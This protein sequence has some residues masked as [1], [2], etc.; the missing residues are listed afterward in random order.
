METIYSLLGYPQETVESRRRQ[1]KAVKR[2]TLLSVCVA[3][4]LAGGLNAAT[5]EVGPGKTYTSI[6]A[7]PLGVPAT[8]RQRADLLAIHTVQGKMGDRPAGHRRSPI[9]VRG[10]AGPAGQLPVIDGN[11]ATTRTALNYWNE[12]RGLLKIGGSNVPPDTTPQYLVIENLEFRSARPPYTFTA[13]NGSTQSY[14]NNAASIYVE[15]GQHITI[16]NCILDDSGNGL[17]IGSP[18]DAAVAGFPDRRQLYLRQRQRRQ[19]VRAQQLF[20]GDRYRIPVQPLRPSARRHFGKQSQ[21]PLGRAGGPLQLDRRRQP[22][23]RPGRCRRQ[24]RDRRGSLLSHHA[25]LRKHSDRA[26]Q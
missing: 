8:G 24:Q 4:A 10:V 5:Y 19:C 22:P 21:G 26:R 7:V 14:V 16:R 6:G 1:T 20:R 11:G 17:F 15:K 12:V 2:L 18:A 25:G 23:A 9:T 13:A 3:L